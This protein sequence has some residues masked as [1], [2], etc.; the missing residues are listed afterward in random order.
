MSTQNANASR[1]LVETDRFFGFEDVVL[2]PAV[3][4]IPSQEQPLDAREVKLASTMTSPMTRPTSSTATSVKSAPIT[5]HEITRG[6]TIKI[7]PA[8]PIATSTAI[9]AK[10]V[11]PTGKNAQARLDALQRT[12]D[13]EC[14]FCCAV[15]DS[16]KI[17]GEG[18]AS[19]SVFFVGEVPT[20]AEV[21][22]ER[23]LAGQSGEKLAEMIRAM[24][25]RSEDVYFANVL[26]TRLPELRAPS[27]LELAQCAPYLRAQIEIIQPTVIVTLGGPA[28]KHV[29]ASEL[30]ITRLRGIWG[31]FEIEGK[32][33]PVMPTFH[34]AYLLRNYT[35]ETRAAVW[36]DLKQVM[37]KL[38]R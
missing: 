12:H 28:T 15:H 5:P 18:S 31:A 30:G 9:T 2:A 33:I 35:A 6:V 7:A 8:P 22:S 4:S 34:P 13:A 27:A 11:L 24:K 1:V 26:K 19:A 20:D 14:P 16:V 3:A 17:F 36:S 23:P 10:I 25:L 32:S 21:A 38:S 29:L 37:E